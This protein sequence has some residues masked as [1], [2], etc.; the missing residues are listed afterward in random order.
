M[1]LVN[2]ITLLKR[3]QKQGK[4]VC[5]FNIE[6]MDMARA[7]AECA[8]EINAPVIIQ[9]TYTT[10]NYAGA[11]TLRAM[12]AGI[13]SSVAGVDIAL[14]LDH[15]NS[16][17]VCKQCADAGYSSVMIDGSR[18]PLEDNIALTAEVCRYAHRKG[19]SA[20][21]EIGKVGGVEDGLE[22]KVAYTDVEECIR[23]VRES[24]VDFVAVGVGTAH[25]EYKGKPVIDFERIAALRN[26]VS[27]P[28][29]LHGASGLDEDTL[30]QCVQAGIAKINFATEL[31]QAYTKGVRLSLADAKVYDPKVYQAIGREEV[32]KVIFEKLKILQ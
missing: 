5:A 14:H 16:F 31:R 22:S 32:K 15:G 20:E 4:A 12:V 25:G 19:L 17:E 28:L 13:V 24:K 1:P 2:T 7:V 29:V 6:N 21:G 30:I 11:K 9:T 23:F 26:A 27:A 8:K 18:L 10:V 3:A